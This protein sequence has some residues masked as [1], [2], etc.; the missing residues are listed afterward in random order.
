[1]DKLKKDKTLSSEEIQ[2]IEKWV[3]GDAEFYTKMCCVV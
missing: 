3:I 2:L 1:V